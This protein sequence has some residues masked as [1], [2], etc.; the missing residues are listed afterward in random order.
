MD[1]I[2][3]EPDR[4]RI[5]VAA[6]QSRC[7]PGALPAG[8]LRRADLPR[9]PGSG[10]GGQAGHDNGRHLDGPGT[11]ASRPYRSEGRRIL[12]GWSLRWPDRAGVAMAGP[13]PAMRRPPPKGVAPSTIR[14]S[15]SGACSAF[16]RG[17]PRRSEVHNP[18]EFPQSTLRH[19]SLYT[20]R[21][22]IFLRIRLTINT[23]K[24]TAIYPKWRHKCQIR[25][26]PMSGR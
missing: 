13:W 12:P 4:S 23:R 20:V 15:S 5:P 16:S 3:R 10:G 19:K 11:G 14:R 25:S 9:L 1:F 22:S 18:I 17:R 7:R 8:H 2:D 24:K 6:R 21:L 26:I